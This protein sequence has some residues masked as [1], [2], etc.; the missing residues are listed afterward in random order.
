MPKASFISCGE[1]SPQRRKSRKEAQRREDSL[2][3]YKG[4]LRVESKNRTDWVIGR[5]KITA[6]AQK[7]Q[8]S[9]KKKSGNFFLTAYSKFHSDGVA[10]LEICQDV[11][12]CCVF[13][14]GNLLLGYMSRFGY[15][16]LAQSRIFPGFMKLK[17]Y[18]NKLFF[19]IEIFPK[20]PVL[21]RFFEVRFKSF[22]WC[23]KFVPQARTPGLKYL[24]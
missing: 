19:F 23:L 16:L 22:H 21:Q 7:T 6:K 18:L 2:Q 9:A 8:R 4:K 20:I 15:F 14:F 11:A 13:N 1:D 24:S 17:R 5:K 3:R 10:D 12:V